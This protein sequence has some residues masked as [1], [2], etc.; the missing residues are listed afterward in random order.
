MWRPRPP[1]LLNEETALQAEH[2][3]LVAEYLR[4]TTI[5]CTTAEL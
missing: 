1:E 4:L 5:G 3:A 2:D